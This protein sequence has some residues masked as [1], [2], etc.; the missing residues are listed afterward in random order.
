MT[1][2]SNLP[3]GEEEFYK[4]LPALRV[5]IGLNLKFILGLMNVTVYIQ[6][7]IRKHYLRREFK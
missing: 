2:N 3:T 6:R 5:H 1:E 4:A 7:V